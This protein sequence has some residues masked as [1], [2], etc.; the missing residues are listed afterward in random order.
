MYRDVGVPPSI[1]LYFYMNNLG[2]LDSLGQMFG[3][4]GPFPMATV[5]GEEAAPIVL[6][7]LLI[8]LACRVATPRGPPAGGT[9]RRLIEVRRGGAGPFVPQEVAASTP[10]GDLVGGAV[11]QDAWIVVYTVG[12]VKGTWRIAAKDRHLG[13]G[14]FVEFGWEDVLRVSAEVAE[15]L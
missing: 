14:D 6:D 3:I 7:R 13:L 2:Y 8:F 5:V 15:T 10:V 11:L 1:Q 12:D 9:A 4:P